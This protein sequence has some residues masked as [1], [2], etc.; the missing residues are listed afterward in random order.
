MKRSYVQ[1]LVLLFLSQ[2]ISVFL[3]AQ[4]LPLDIPVSFIGGHVITTPEEMEPLIRN[5]GVE[6][7]SVLEVT[8][9]IDR[10]DSQT[11]RKMCC[12]KNGWCR[13]LGEDLPMTS[14]KNVRYDAAN[15]VIGYDYYHADFRGCSVGGH[16]T[17]N[18]HSYVHNY[19]E[20]DKI[21]QSVVKQ[22][23]VSPTGVSDTDQGAW[24][25]TKYAYDRN[26]QMARKLLYRTHTSDSTIVFM[27]GEL[28]S[29]SSAGRERWQ[30]AL[31][32]EVDLKAT[33]NF[34]KIAGKFSEI[35]TR[36]TK[37][38]HDSFVNRD[39][40]KWVESDDDEDEVKLQQA[41]EKR[42]SID[43]AILTSTFKWASGITNFVYDRSGLIVKR[44][45]IRLFGPPE[46]FIT[47]TFTYNTNKQ[48]TSWQ[49]SDL[50]GDKTNW[51]FNYDNSG[52]VIQCIQKT[53]KPQSSRQKYQPEETKTYTLEYNMENWVSA[54][55]VRTVN[56]LGDHTVRL[57]FGYKKY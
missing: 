36:Q 57:L 30:A 6:F 49:T 38:L 31:R 4:S 41:V 18:I 33:E 42:D 15:N 1:L 8:K 39:F 55:D 52:R 50:T 23:V 43:N 35:Y 11:Y 5:S 51:I 34:D 54:A 40:K 28:Y 24:F 7:V 53:F 32:S 48:M 21:V 37:Q 14:F 9:G 47:D 10:T 46:M 20:K 16:S 17:T 3:H 12:F 56:E 13:E 44:V 22:Q 45:S 25:V 26:G 19:F 29:W 2:A 27:E